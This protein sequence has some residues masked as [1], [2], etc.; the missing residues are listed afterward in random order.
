MELNHFTRKQKERM[1]VSDNPNW[2]NLWEEPQFLEKSRLFSQ[3]PEQKERFKSRRK[4]MLSTLRHEFSRYIHKTDEADKKNSTIP[5]D[6]K[7][8]SNTSKTAQSNKIFPN[9]LMD[10]NFSWKKNS[11]SNDYFSNSSFK[12]PQKAIFYSQFP[13]LNSIPSEKE[14]PLS[15]SI[16]S[17]LHLHQ[18]DLFENNI[19]V[20]RNTIKEKGKKLK[21]TSVTKRNRA[22]AQK[23][24]QEYSLF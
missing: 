6:A 13:G 19:P 11:L 22:G 1:I 9:S 21:S 17:R 7:N 10:S 3:I 4:K 23:N 16:E 8:R 12:N 20:P 24:L 18:I 5:T 15:G 2:S 14:A